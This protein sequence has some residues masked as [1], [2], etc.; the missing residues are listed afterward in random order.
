MLECL[1]AIMEEF[2]AKMMANMDVCVA[3]MRAWQK[4]VTPCREATEACL[5][6]AKEP[7]SVKIESIAVHEEVPKDKAAVK[8]V[9]ALKKQYG[10]QHLAIG[11]S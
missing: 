2:E 1:L 10:D 7:N 4:E 6:K 11:C 5:E 8:T 9:R 3:E